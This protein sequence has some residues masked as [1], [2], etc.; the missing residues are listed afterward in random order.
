MKTKIKNPSGDITTYF[1]E[2]KRII[3]EKNH[4]R[5]LRTT[6]CQQQDKLDGMEK[7]LETHKLPKLTQ[8]S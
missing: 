3:R 2:I 6:V 7:F 1:I 5:I 8:K 4:K